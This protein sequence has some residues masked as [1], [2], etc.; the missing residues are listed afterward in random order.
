MRIAVCD[1]E[2][3]IL[4]S[5]CSYI[6]E[7]E[8]TAGKE[9]TEVFTFSS[10]AALGSAIEDGAVF[11]VFLLDVYIGEVLGTALAKEIRRKGIESP[12][13]FLTTSVEHAPEGFE[14]SALR[15]LI[16]PIDREKFFEA[17]SAAEKQSE[18][19]QERFVLLKTA[20]SVERVNISHIYYTEAHSHYQYITLEGKERV[21]VRMT[22]TELFD[23]L[24]GFGGFV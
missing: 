1:D 7:Y 11:D 13:I 23:L 12:I 21:K 5:I 6:K 4:K 24:E 10:A 17:L 14:V 2:K 15:Y 19:M 16:K 8:K 9:G 22:V 20:D 18:R 3:I